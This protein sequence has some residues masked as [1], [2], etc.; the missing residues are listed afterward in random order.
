MHI[1]IVI[2]FFLLN[3]V[4]KKTGSRKSRYIG[5]VNC[6]KIAFAAVV[7]LFEI[8]KRINIPAKETAH[9]LEIKSLSKFNFLF[10]IKE[11]IKIVK[12]AIEDL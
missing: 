8:T 5:A 7:S 3:F 12:A 1:T 11:I 9:K 6:R 2:R 10:R 4:F